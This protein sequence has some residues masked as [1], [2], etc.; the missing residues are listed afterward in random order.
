M[1]FVVV[2]Q[3]YTTKDNN[4]LRPTTKHFD[5]QIIFLHSFVTEEYFFVAPVVENFQLLYR[6]FADG[7]KQR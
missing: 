4:I 6:P 2:T 3:K 1:L 7:A 5:N